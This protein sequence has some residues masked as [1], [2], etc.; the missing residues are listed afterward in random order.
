MPDP[1]PTQILRIVHREDA[2]DYILVTLLSFAGSVGL[3]RLYLTLSGYP[4]IG[5]GEIHIAHVL[6]GGLLLF[7]AAIAPLILANR[8]VFTA[9][10]ALAG[11][12]VGLFIDEV[13]KFI[14]T[15]NDYFY[16]AAAPIVYVLFLLVVLLYLRVR[17]FPDTSPDAELHRAL[18]DMR[19][20]LEHPIKAQK[21]GRL[22]SR[23]D[24]I[25]GSSTAPSHADLARSLLRF[26]EAVGSQPASSSPGPRWW[27]KV[28]VASRTFP[29]ATVGHSRTLLAIGL[30]IVGLLM[31]KNP[32]NTWISEWLPQDLARVLGDVAGRHIDPTTSPVWFDVRLALEVTLG[33]LLVVSA[34]LLAAGRVRI[35]SALA[36]IVLILSLTTLNLLLFYFEQFSTIITTT[37]QF[38]LVFAL[39]RYRRRPQLAEADPASQVLRS[40]RC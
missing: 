22:Q 17:K 14:T 9:S 38:V 8:W 30:L 35:G 20:V 39:I 34:G 19:E 31:L 7:G 23:L 37:I 3:T 28:R 15:R 6:W 13:G 18:G 27:S 32:A 16:P 2:E 36:F 10:A 1:E 40:E 5:G 26:V 33:F 29:S 21:R 25:A 11:V 4:Q 24:R 12:G